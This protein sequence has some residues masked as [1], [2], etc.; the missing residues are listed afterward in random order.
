MISKLHKTTC[1][2]VIKALREI[3]EEEQYADKVVEHTLRSNPKF[4][5]RDR[6]FIAQT[7]YDCVRWWRLLLAQAGFESVGKESEYWQLVGT[8]LRK[9]SVELPD[10]EEW[11]GVPEV[12]KEDISFERKIRCAIPDWLDETGLN[13][14]GSKWEKEVEA[15]NE[16]TDVVLRV[17]TLK[18][19]KQKLIQAFAKQSIKVEEVEGYN[20]ALILTE[21]QNL[22]QTA[23]Y[24]KGWFEIQDASSQ[25]I[26]DF[27]DLKPNLTVVDA[28]AGAGGKSLHI[29]ARLNNSGRIISM[30]VEPRKLDE[31][32]KRA[33]RGGVTN[34]TTK[35]IIN[36]ETIKSLSAAA[37]RL[38]LDVP[39]S[40][41][42][43][44]KRNPD[45]KW[46]L[47]PEFLKE[48]QSTQANILEN[49]STMLKPNGLLVYA[50]CSILPSENNEQVATFLA[51][52]PEFELLKERVVLPSE[53]F[54]GFYMAALKKIS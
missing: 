51:H 43:V 17:N 13:E 36:E 53:G 47:T 16:P 15:L 37:D 7:I 6:R 25:L 8:Y 32:K 12:L 50:T 41:L 40:G 26:A 29:A 44:L 48:L 18:T 1:L 39:C 23:E 49:Y 54:D 3:F 2:A 4:G 24:K 5:S 42:G 9:Q 10:W 38:L 46:K 22:A 52:H 30:D 34:I 27:L 45:T 28:C 33:F 35:T 31:L 19:N 14:L 11:R 21:R 20:D